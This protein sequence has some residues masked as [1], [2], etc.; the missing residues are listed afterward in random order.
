MKTLQEIYESIAEPKMVPGEKHKKGTESSIPVRRE[1]GSVE[2]FDSDGD[3]WWFKDL[4]EH[5][6]RWYGENGKLHRIGKPALI[7]RSTIFGNAN[8][9]WIDG[10]L[11]REDGYAI[12]NLDSP[13][14]SEY[15][16]NNVR[17]TE[18]EFDEFLKLKKI[19]HKGSNAAGV[20]LD[21]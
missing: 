5:S 18:Q 10:R 17:I 11:H 13:E 16:L 4:G 8:Q 12:E 21:V 6:F 19:T 2:L 9:W 1:N 20:N 15:W 7:V 14:N 3:V